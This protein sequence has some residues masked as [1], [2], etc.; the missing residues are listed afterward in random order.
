MGEKRK[1]ERPSPGL[2]ATLSHPMGEGLGVRALLRVGSWPQFACTSRWKLPRK[3]L[4]GGPG[5]RQL[6][7]GTC[8]R[9]DVPGG[10]KEGTPIEA[11]Q[12]HAGELLILCSPPNDAAQVGDIL[13]DVFERMDEL[14]LSLRGSGDAAHIRGAAPR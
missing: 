6:A 14:D 8:D 10:I 5:S 4:E 1:A 2:A 3:L 7:Q 11:G 12:A 13:Q 9:Q